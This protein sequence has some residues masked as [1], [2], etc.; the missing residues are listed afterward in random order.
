[1][2]N[3]SPTARRLVTGG[4]LERDHARAFRDRLEGQ[5]E[6]AQAWREAVPVVPLAPVSV[7]EDR[8]RLGEVGHAGVRVVGEEC[9]LLLALAE[10]LQAEPAGP[11]AGGGLRDGRVTPHR[12]A[13]VLAD[14]AGDVLGDRC[15]GEVQ[16]DCGQLVL[17]SSVVVG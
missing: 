6:P 12:V 10:R 16:C 1:M 5:L 4:S 14:V 17:S 3:S 2:S 13:T 9:P 8:P 7:D 11:E 15:N